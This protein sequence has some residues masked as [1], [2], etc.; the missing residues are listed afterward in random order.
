MPI[1][2]RREETTFKECSLCHAVWRTKED[3]LNDP[4]LKLNGYQFTSVRNTNSANGGI[5]LYTHTTESC[6]TTLA[7]YVRNFK[8]QPWYGE[9]KA[10]RPADRFSEQIEQTIHKGG[11]QL[12]LK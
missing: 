5:L 8:E 2:A 9:R 10:H 4:E 1:S 11:T 12:C 6:G 7:I 3:F